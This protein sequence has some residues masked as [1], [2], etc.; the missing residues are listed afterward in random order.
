MTYKYI[1]IKRADID[2]MMKA[3]K[4]SH[5]VSSNKRSRYKAVS[6]I[7]YISIW[8]TIFIALM[9][10]IKFH[11]LELI[12]WLIPLTVLTITLK[13]NDDLKFDKE[14]MIDWLEELIKKE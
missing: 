13:I 12:A 5:F 11:N 3:L 7:F 9:F 8:A 10:I 6:L 4:T 14:V 2:Y 1:K